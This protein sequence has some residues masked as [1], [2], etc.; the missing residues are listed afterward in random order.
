MMAGQW[1][2]VDGAV[3]GLDLPELIT[4]HR[5]AA[6]RLIDPARWNPPHLDGTPAVPSDNKDVAMTDQ[7]TDSSTAQGKRPEDEKLPWAARSR[8]ASST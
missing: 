3:V 1:R 2:V 4:A 6:A 7:N 5:A 8:T